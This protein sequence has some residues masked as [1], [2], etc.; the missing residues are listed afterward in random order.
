[1]GVNWLIFGFESG[2]NARPGDLEWIRRGVAQCREYGATPFVK[3]LGAKW[4][5]STRRVGVRG[6][7]IVP[8]GEPF[9]WVKPGGSF[10]EPEDWPED[11]RVQEFPR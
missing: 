4:Y 9:D 11:L 6:S 8:A 3:Q 1:M 5:D 2:H 10:A 7:V